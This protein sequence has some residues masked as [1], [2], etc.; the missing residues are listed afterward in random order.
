MTDAEKNALMGSTKEELIDMIDGMRETVRSAEEKARK[1]VI[2]NFLHGSKAA[3][4]EADDDE[5]SGVFD[6][7]S[8]KSF[9]ELKKHFR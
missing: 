7:K 6:L 9:S 8:N 1:D 3:P 5:D 2:E 4:E